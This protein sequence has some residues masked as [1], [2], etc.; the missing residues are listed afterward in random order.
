MNSQIKFSDREISEMSHEADELQKSI[1]K[2]VDEFLQS[3]TSSVIRNLKNIIIIHSAARAF[4]FWIFCKYK[5]DF[6]SKKEFLELVTRD[7]DVYWDIFHLEEG[8][9]KL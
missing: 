1:L 7:M 8:Y 9:E 3:K 5:D 6:S 4:Y 2:A